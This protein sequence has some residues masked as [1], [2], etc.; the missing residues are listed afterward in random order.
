MAKQILSCDWGTSSFRLRLVNVDD[1]TILKEVLAEKGIAAMYDEWKQI[2]RDE[3]ERIGFYKTFLQAIL[4][5]HF[6]HIVKGLPVMISGMASSTIG[7][8][9]LEY[10][11]VPFNLSGDNL[12]SF[13]IKSDD[14]CPH[15]VILISGLRTANDVMRGEETM[16]LGCD[17]SKE[18]DALV[19]FPGTHS[20]HVS[21][22]NNI[23][24]GFKTYMTGEVFK[25]L[26]IKSVLSKSVIKNKSYDQK[27]FITGVKEGA[28]NNLLNSAFH[29]RTNQLFKK[30]SEEE[31]YHFLSGLVIGYELKEVKAEECAYLVCSNNLSQQYLAALEALNMSEVQYYDAD[32]VLIKA[33]CKLSGILSL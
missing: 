22:K 11:E 25:L 17:I 31:N 18:E 10:S 12:N 23:A 33:H 2:K 30:F 4:D 5:K 29:V 32:K 14:V 15:D 20:K 1:E 3:S 8:K 9:E 19:I 13:K 6:G 26:S 7:M 16:L 27:G 28:S 24:I 21:V